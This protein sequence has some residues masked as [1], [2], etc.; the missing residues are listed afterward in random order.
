[1]IEEALQAQAAERVSIAWEQAAELDTVEGYE[2]FIKDFPNGRLAEEAQARITAMTRDPEEVAAEE[3]AKAAEEAL[4]LN[5]R[6][7]TLVEDRLTKL[8]LKPGKVDGE[9]TDETR[10]AIRRYQDA[11][12]MPVTGYLNQNTVVR[13]MAD[14]LFR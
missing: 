7:R 10:R 6:T 8:G 4:G 11:R 9:F 13:L 12:G 3:R 14:A 5:R 2:A 1:V